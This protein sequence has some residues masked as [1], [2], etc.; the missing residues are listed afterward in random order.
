MIN[1]LYFSRYKKLIA[2]YQNHTVDGF[3][4]KHHI[5][6][7]CLGGTN[8]KSNI[9]LLPA[10]VHFIAHAFLYKAFPKEP[11]LA[12]AFGMM[13]AANRFHKER[14]YN[15]KLYEMA[16]YARSNSM[17]GISRPDWVKEK[18]R[19][20]KINKKNYKKPKTKEHAQNISKSLKGKKK[21]QEHINK[22]VESRKKFNA[23]KSEEMLQKI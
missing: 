12:Q 4:E 17:K 18:L 5:I 20:P 10:R 6:P 19:V 3:Y 9:V 15:S 13:L 22:I 1:T 16:K 14:K 11:K 2:H 7:K 21:T 8:E 23:K